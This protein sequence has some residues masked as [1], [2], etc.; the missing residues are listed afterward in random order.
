MKLLDSRLCL[1]CYTSSRIDRVH[2]SERKRLLMELLENVERRTELFVESHPIVFSEDA[3]RSVKEELNSVALNA[4][5]DLY[6]DDVDYLLRLSCA[7]NAV[8]ISN[9]WYEGFDLVDELGHAMDR[10]VGGVDRVARILE[11]AREIAVLLDNAG[12]AVVDIALG[13]ALAERGAKVYLVA[14]SASYEVDVVENEVRD[15]VNRVAEA[16]S[17]EVGDVHVV[18]T[19]GRYP[20]PARGKVSNVVTDLLRRV[21][22]VISKG[23]ANLEAFI[24]YGF[25]HPEKV[26][27]LVKSKCPPIAKLL[28]ASLGTPVIGVLNEVVKTRG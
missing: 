21:D 7:A 28:N 20:A 8:D 16:L 15:L 27:L 12:E 13:L 25:E 26:V 22:V 17:I 4:L 1:D 19:G 6:R 24:D 23:I 9:P 2:D 3:F 18:G 10:I 5:S 14:R 11:K